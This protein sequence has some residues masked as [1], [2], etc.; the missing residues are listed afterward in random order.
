MS[1]ARIVV[2]CHGRN[3]SSASSANGLNVV[4]NAHETVRDII[5]AAAWS[6]ALPAAFPFRRESDFA[7]GAAG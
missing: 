5:I 6:I 7:L 1:T 3:D 4:C 2:V